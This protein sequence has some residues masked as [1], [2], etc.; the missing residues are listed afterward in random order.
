MDWQS[1]PHHHCRRRRRHCHPSEQR[2][3]I[4]LEQSGQ[5][6]RWQTL[7]CSNF[8]LHHCHTECD[9]LLRT[10]CDTHCYAKCNTL[11]RKAEYYTLLRCHIV[12][13]PRRDINIVA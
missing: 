4:E 7:E 2:K 6:S 3:V 5:Q 1:H 8:T 11:L 12:L 9:I 10:R 13:V